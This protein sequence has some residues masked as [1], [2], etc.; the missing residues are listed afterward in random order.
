MHQPRI[1]AAPYDDI[2]HIIASPTREE[3]LERFHQELVAHNRSPGWGC[4]DPE[5]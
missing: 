5:R 3:A 1:E 4:C 2:T